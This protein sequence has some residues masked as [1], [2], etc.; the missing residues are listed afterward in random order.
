ME[1][2]KLMRY[3]RL[4]HELVHAQYNEETGKWHLKLR[5]PVYSTPT[6]DQ[7]LRYE[8][9]EDTADLVFSGVG[10]LSRWRWPDIDGLTDFDGKVVHSADWD[11]KDGQTWQNSVEDWKEKRVGVIGVVSFN[12]FWQLTGLIK[13]L[14]ERVHQH[15]RLSPLYNLASNK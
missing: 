3:I 12:M 2:Y 13:W 15:Y 10:G 4:Q 7:E 8:V 11:S 5:R 1:K 6:L 14:D 9:I